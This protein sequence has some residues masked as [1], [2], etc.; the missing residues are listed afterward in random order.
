MIDGPIDAVGYAPY[1]ARFKLTDNSDEQVAVDNNLLINQQA[2]YNFAY[3][4]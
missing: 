4:A 1:S 3:A 2:A